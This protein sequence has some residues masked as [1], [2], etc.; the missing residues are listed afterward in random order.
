[1]KMQIERIDH[2]GV[3]AGTIKTRCCG[4]PDPDAQACLIW[5]PLPWSAEQFSERRSRLG[6][7]A[8]RARHLLFG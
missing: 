7:S 2:L 1:M 4:N 3:V 5:R 6:G 8:A